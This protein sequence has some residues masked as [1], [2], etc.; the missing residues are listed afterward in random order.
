MSAPGDIFY[1]QLVRGFSELLRGLRSS[2]P[3]LCQRSRES[4]AGRDVALR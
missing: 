3:R 4:L 1:I 2:L